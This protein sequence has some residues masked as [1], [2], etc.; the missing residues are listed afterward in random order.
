MMAKSAKGAAASS[1]KADNGNNGLEQANDNFANGYFEHNNNGKGDA[2]LANALEHNPFSRDTTI[3]F[4]D[5]DLT[6]TGE[7]TYYYYGYPYYD[8]MYGTWEEDGYTFTFTTYDYNYY[9]YYYGD[10]DIDVPVFDAD[11]DGD[12][13]L[14]TND[15][16]TNYNY[17]DYEY[18]YGSLTNNDGSNFS[19]LSFDAELVDDGNPN[20][21]YYDY[22]QFYVSEYDATDNSYN[23]GYA[24]TYDDVTWSYYEYDYDYDTG[25]YTSYSS[26]STTDEAE[27]AALFDDVTTLQIYISGDFTLDDIVL[28][29]VA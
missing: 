27:V 23:Y 24:Y 9:S 14:G 7:Y 13:E 18:T 29:E 4:D 10:A 2:G 21:Y 3:D 17:Y 25:T 8:E 26:G 20:Y 19:L 6:I 5:G 15:L 1:A 22:V 11:G 28:D 12:N 16:G